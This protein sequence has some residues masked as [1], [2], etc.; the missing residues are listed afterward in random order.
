MNSAHAA[1]D[2]AISQIDR[3][4]KTLRKSA[5]RQVQSN[6][7]RALIKATAL[8][9]FNEHRPTIL[10]TVDKDTLFEIDDDFRILI[11]S[12]DRAC[13]RSTYFDALT[14]LRRLLSD[15][16]L[17]TL[18][19]SSSPPTATVDT[20]P[21]FSKLVTNPQMTEILERR[22]RECARCIEAEANLAAIVM[23]GGLL[24]ALLLARV[25]REPSKGQ[26]F[27]AS[28]APKD[29]TTRKTLPLNEW[30]LKHYIDV[31]HEL[32]WISQ[33]ARD[34]GAVMRDYR[35]YIHPYKELSHGVKIGP[36]DAAMFWE[37]SKSITR[38][39]LR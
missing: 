23:I 18:I 16:R 38:Q 28:T 32:K 22:W 36:D 6:D 20:P 14:T 1:V 33:S 31:A 26:V 17:E 35:N 15:L 30:T 27:K 39:L 34:V 29:K 3:L 7:E 5:S 11:S 9:W 12:T 21:D 13:A 19:P 8:A 37:I 2:L 10:S 24:E 25:N 4:R